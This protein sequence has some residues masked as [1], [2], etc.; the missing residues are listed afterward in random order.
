MR[1][2]LDMSQEGFEEILKEFPPKYS[3]LK[4][5]ARR[6]RHILSPLQNGVLWTGTDD[7]PEGTAG[8]Y[9]GVMQAF[10]EA[11]VSLRG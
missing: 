7:S 6:L 4:P 2:S 11:R 1:K 9:D 10:E 8:L 3:A 5:L